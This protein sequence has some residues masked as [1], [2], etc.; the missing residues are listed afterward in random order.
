MSNAMTYEKAPITKPNP[1]RV[2]TALSENILS[3]YGSSALLLHV[4]KRHKYILVVNLLI[5]ENLYLVLH[6]FTV[7]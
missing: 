5:A 2:T 3:D 1:K 6:Y 4:A 7:I